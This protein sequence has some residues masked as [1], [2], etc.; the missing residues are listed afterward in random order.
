MN[1]GV[2][3]TEEQ[4]KRMDELVLELGCTNWSLIAFEPGTNEYN[5]YTQI[6]TPA[7]LY[8]LLLIMRDMILNAVNSMRATEGV[9]GTEG[10]C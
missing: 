9:H 4:K 1:S 6:D 5:A 2:A 7:E 3:I 10:N 8:Q